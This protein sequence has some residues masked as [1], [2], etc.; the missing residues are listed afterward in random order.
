MSAHK[1]TSHFIERNNV[2]LHHLDWGNEG[3]HPVVLVH[4]VRLH[5][6][7][8]NHFSRRYRDRF[9]IMALDQRGH[10]ESGWGHHEHYHPEEYYHDLVHM[11]K[12]RGLKRFTL[13]GHSLGGRVSMLFASRHPELLERLVLVD[14]TPGRPAGMSATADMSRITETPPP[15]DY[16]SPQEAATYLK[17]IMKLAPPEGI[18]ESVEHG[19]RKMENGRYTWK[20]DPALF[21]RPAP[22]PYNMWDVVKKITVP[23]LLLYG[24]HSNVVNK[25]LAEQLAATMPNCTI[26]RIERAG[27]GLFTDQPEAFA[28]GVGRFLGVA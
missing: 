25:E 6:H 3:K 13:I 21:R 27:H 4:G 5:A 16:E 18:D 23:T 19:M 10:G 28:E 7:V 24:S 22:L 2:K 14:I 8:W 15:Q 9:H 12:G 11:V 20:Y 1:P 26:Q 17:K